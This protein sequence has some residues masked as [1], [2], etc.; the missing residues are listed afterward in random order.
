MT[1]QQL[2]RARD[3]LG[4]LT[5]AELARLLGYDGEAGR[6]QIC[7]MESGQRTIRPAQERLIRAYLDGYRP[8]D[9]P[10]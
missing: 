8:K 5:Q 2:I 4:G 10:R 1:P 9:W 3:R 6:A 7:L